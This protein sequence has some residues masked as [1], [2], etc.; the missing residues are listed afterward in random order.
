MTTGSP[1]PSRP[2][3]GEAIC[4]LCGGEDAEVLFRGV[5]KN[6]FDAAITTDLY[7]A[8][9]RVVRC[10]GCGLVFRSPRENDED[11]LAAY[12]DME[13]AG[14]LDEEECRHMNA[15]LSLKTIRRHVRGG[16]L[17][18]VGCSLGFFLNAARFNFE[19]TGVEPCRW[20][21]THARERLRLDV[22]SD[23]PRP[24]LFPVKHFDAVVL[25]DV[26]E[27]VPRP[28]DLIRLC[29]GWI[30]PGGVIYIVTPDVRSLSARFLGR[31][32]WGYR[33]AH[34]HYF[35][36]NT[37][38]RLLHENGFTVV[39]LKSYGRIFTWGY[40]VSRLRG[41]PRWVEAPVSFFVRHLGLADKEL[42]LNTRDSLEVV[43][44]FDRSPT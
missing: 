37:L 25:I 32:W 4:D 36:K 27:H 29:A 16:R 5:G 22:R 30:R 38:E 13:D 43:A 21:A 12:R 2:E 39:Q 41:Y 23:P 1:P 7:G 40:W 44:R 34:L 31:R 24:G 19:T 14:Y 6:R 3:A 18:E 20:A 17:L 28:Q 15:H 33:A 10:R 26:L 35:S 8:V 9:G 42:Y 11:I